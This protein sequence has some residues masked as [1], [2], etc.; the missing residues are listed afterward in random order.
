MSELGD[1]IR[2][3]NVRFSGIVQEICGQ[4]Q[5]S[6]CHQGTMMGLQ[7]LRRLARGVALEPGFAARLREGLHGR[8]EELARDLHVVEK[9]AQLLQAT[10]LPADSERA[11]P[12]LERRIA[13][14]RRLVEYMATDYPLT[15]E[16]FTPLLHY[17]AVRHNLI[18]CLR[19]FP[20][21]EAALSTLSRGQGSFAFRGRKMAPPRCIFHHDRCLAEHYKPIKCASFFC[22][23]EPNLLAHCREAMSFDDFVLSTLRV[24]SRDFAARMLSLESEWGADYWEP[25][26]I[27]GS[28]AETTAFLDEVAATLR[29]QRPVV[30]EDREPGRFMKATNEIL[31]DIGALAPGETLVYRCAAV[32]GAALYE[33]AVAADR[34]RSQDWHGGLVLLAEQLVPR[35]FMAHPLWEDQMISQPLGGLEA[36]FCE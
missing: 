5:D 21:A 10:G 19:G 24:V 28:G 20:G 7:G 33:L 4:C 23:N 15:V 26:V 9:V 2:A 8:R 17:T 6:C 22:T 34:A 35:S 27:V 36:Y 14:L 29:Q 13:D 18:R 1:R 11:L 31:A 12:E 3:A 32:D 30:R 25:L 16:G